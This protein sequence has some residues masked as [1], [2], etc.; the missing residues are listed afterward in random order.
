[1]A[2]IEDKLKTVDS[3]FRRGSKSY[4]AARYIVRQNRE[5]PKEEGDALIEE[6]EITPKSLEYVVTKLR[7]LGLYTFDID[8]EEYEPDIPDDPETLAIDEEEIQDTIPKENNYA[9]IEDLNSLRDGLQSSLN[10]LTS[11]ILGEP[12]TEEEEA[13]MS[14]RLVEIST[15]DEMAIG[16]PSLTRKSIWLKPKTQMYFDLTRQGLFTSYAGSNEISVL[17]G[18]KGNLSDFFNSIIDD[19][20]VRNF[21]ADIG[22][23]MRRYV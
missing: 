9:T 18:F 13:Y 2:S 20:F 16:D 23:L 1:L 11:A 14:D 6:L 4:K 3:K 7:N 5:L 17:N 21:N 8:L 12:E 10:Q 19:Y 22:I 15:P